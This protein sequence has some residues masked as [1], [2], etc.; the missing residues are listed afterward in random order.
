[1]SERFKAAH[2]PNDSKNT[3]LPIADEFSNYRFGRDALAHVSRYLWIGEQVIE[4]AREEGRPV[5]LLDVGC[6]DAYVARVLQASFRVKKSETVA[7]YVGLDMDGVSLQRTARSMPKAFSWELIPGDLTDGGLD[8]RILG[9]EGFDL[10]ICTEV[11]EHVQPRFVLPILEGFH[12][13]APRALVSTPNWT[14]GSGRLPQDHVKEWDYHDLL[15]VMQ[16]AGWHVARSFGTF[17]QLRRL[18]DSAE[19]CGFGQVVAWLRL[20][21]DKHFRALFLARLVP[22][23]QAQNVMYVLEREDG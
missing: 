4:L 8:Q 7:R 12:G 13:L 20:N 17:G 22:P 21:A 1:M 14:G 3:R 5:R 19:A 9:E 11:L 2:N 23:E 16:D 6:G 18:E 15:A 10:I